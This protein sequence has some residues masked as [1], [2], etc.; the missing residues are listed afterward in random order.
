MTV[1]ELRL[2]NFR[3]LFT[4][5]LPH[6]LLISSS[7]RNTLYSALERSICSSPLFRLALHTVKLRAYFNLQIRTPNGVHPIQARATVLC[8]TSDFIPSLSTRIGLSSTT[9]LI[10]SVFSNWRLY[11]KSPSPFSYIPLI[12]PIA[13][14]IQPCY[15]NGLILLLFRNLNDTVRSDQSTRN[16]YEMSCGARI[17]HTGHISTDR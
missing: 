17:V 3:T 6:A 10:K 4:P 15:L 13:A 2:I 8:S 5:Y 9:R 12:H 14:A 7:K 16:I 11:L 1:K